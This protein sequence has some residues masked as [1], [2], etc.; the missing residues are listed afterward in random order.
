MIGLGLR[1]MG[2]RESIAV[3]REIAEPGSFARGSNIFATRSARNRNDDSPLTAKLEHELSISSGVARWLAWIE[4]VERAQPADF[5]RLARLAQGNVAATRLITARWA[6]IAPRHLFDTLVAASKNGGAL[7]YQEYART[8]WNDW[9][10]RDPAA[11]IAALNEAGSVGMRNQWRR[12]AATDIVNYDPE[13]GLRLMA[14]WH[15][16][17][18]QPNQ[19]GIAKWAAKDPRH[20]AEFTLENAAGTAMVSAMET[21]GKEWSKTDPAG[22]LTFAIG[23]PGEGGTALV[24]EALKKWAGNN[25]EEAANWVAASK[26]S[27]RN[28]LSPALVEAWAKQDAGGALQWCEENLNGSS[29]SQAVAGLMK[30]AAGKDSTGAETL[31]ARMDPSPARTA[32]AIEVARIIFP[33]LSSDKGMNPETI[34]WLNG[35]DPDTTRGVLNAVSWQWAT[36]DPKTMASFLA[37]ASSE[38]VPDYTDSVLARQLASKNLSEALDWAST[39]PPERGIKAGGEAFAEWRRGQPEAATKWLNELPPDDARRQPFFAEAIRSVAYDSQAAVQLAALS[40]AERESAKPVI[41]GMKL[42]ED[43]RARLL[44]ALAT[45]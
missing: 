19:G 33:T 3:R 27:V 21:I 20:A 13:L 43:K 18:H 1:G 4:A 36:S 45:K 5:P 39:L 44:Q 8:L 32:G 31:I 7:L 6:E 30:G 34:D 12:E 17:N 25:L 16:E 2:R 37:T 38:G 35:L 15:I 40:P 22:A 24:A 23:K 11:A 9:P 26:E 41:E 14:Q 10:K 42:P 29:L 28:Q